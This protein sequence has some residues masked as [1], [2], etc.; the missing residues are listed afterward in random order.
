[1]SKKYRSEALEAV[2]ETMKSLYEIGTIDKKT[3]HQFDEAC[4]VPA[5]SLIIEEI[6]RN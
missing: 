2:H 1:M 3:M 6:G 5:H 4:L